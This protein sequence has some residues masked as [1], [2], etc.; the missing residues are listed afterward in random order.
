M[1]FIYYSDD[2]HHRG[3]SDDTWIPADPRN[4]VETFIVD[5]TLTN[6]LHE[7]RRMYVEIWRDLLV[8][9]KYTY[10]TFKKSIYYT[11]NIIQ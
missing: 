8:K 5:Y 9:M 10:C 11:N 4:T 6:E 2:H 3:E 7:R 1:Y